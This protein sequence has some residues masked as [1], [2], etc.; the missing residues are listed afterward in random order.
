MST[1]LRHTGGSTFELDG[2]LTI[3][4]ITNPVT[5]EGEYLGA[6]ENPYGK[7]AAGTAPRPR[8]NAKT[9]T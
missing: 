7:V 2:D 6:A 5:L 9:G 8:S 3:K 1:G 4:D